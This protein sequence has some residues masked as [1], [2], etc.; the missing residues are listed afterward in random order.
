M[1]I[2]NKFHLTQKFKRFR[3]VATPKIGFILILPTFLLMCLVFVVFYINLLVALPI[4][5]IVNPTAKLKNF[6]SDFRR[7]RRKFA[8]KYIFDMIRNI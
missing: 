6:F 7:A 2:Y 5:L 8:E 4:M 1:K 3:K